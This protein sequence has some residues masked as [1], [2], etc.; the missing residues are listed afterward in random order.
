VVVGG[1]DANIQL[2]ASDARVENLNTIGSP[3]EL[4]EA[5]M[6]EPHQLNNTV[7]FGVADRPVRLAVRFLLSLMG[8]GKWR[9]AIVLPSLFFVLKH[10]PIVFLQMT[11]KCETMSKLVST[12]FPQML[13]SRQ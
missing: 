13:L 1:L 3:L 10:F 7:T 4:L 9:M 8:D 12:Y 11:C 6:N 5:I 2:R